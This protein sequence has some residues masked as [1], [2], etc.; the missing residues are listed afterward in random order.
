MVSLTITF[1]I[2]SETIIYVYIS[3]L[4]LVLSFPSLIQT[5]CTNKYLYILHLFILKS[6]WI[7]RAQSHKGFLAGFFFSFPWYSTQG[8]KKNMSAQLTLAILKETLLSQMECDLLI[9][10]QHAHGSKK[11]EIQENFIS[12]ENGVGENYGW[13]GPDMAP[14]ALLSASVPRNFYEGLIMLHFGWDNWNLATTE[15][16]SEAERDYW[17]RQWP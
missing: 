5:I 10:W 3:S 13:W 11:V 1:I 17:K 8:E 4:F 6:L 12:F 15:A 7:F 16:S 2:V 14:N 9:G